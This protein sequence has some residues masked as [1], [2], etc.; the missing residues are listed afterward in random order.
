MLIN[1]WNI[2][3]AVNGAEHL[4]HDTRR[5]VVRNWNCGFV[6]E[7]KASLT[8]GDRGLLFMLRVGSKRKHRKKNGGWACMY[9]VIDYYKTLR[10]L[11]TT[12]MS[13]IKCAY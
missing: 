12:I 3:K 7:E 5:Y 8:N 11:E 6:S 9:M 13:K 2:K 1:F 4:I 10:V